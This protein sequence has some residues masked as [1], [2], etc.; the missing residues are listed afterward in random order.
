M[1]LR[2][3]PLLG[4]SIQERDVDLALLM[5]VKTSLDFRT[6]ICTQL[7]PDIEISQLLSVCRSVDTTTGES[8]VEIAVKTSGG[9]RYLFLIE[10]KINAEVQTRQAERYFKRGDG[11]VARDLCDDYQV[12]LVAPDD[13]ISENERETFGKVISYESILNKLD[14]LSH[15]ATPFVEVL[16]K[17]AI[18]K[19]E[20]GYTAR[21]EVTTA[22]QTRFDE[23]NDEFPEIACYK[24][25]NN[26]VRFRSTNPNHPE[27]IQYTIWVPGGSGREAMVRLSLEGE[28]TDEQLHTLQ[29]ILTDSIDE[30]D[31]YELHADTKYLVRTTVT[32]EEDKRVTNGEYID[33]IVSELRRLTEHYHRKLVNASI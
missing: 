23:R 11:Y 20:S 26:V 5:L 32:T 28:A 22:I 31:G 3:R 29:S 17:R 8:D 14:S 24:C 4:R 16:L 18:E 10:N 9:L 19:Q 13:Y 30:L 1:S 33:S 25:S 2:D 15:D 27:K 21:P 7:H 6:W 12:A